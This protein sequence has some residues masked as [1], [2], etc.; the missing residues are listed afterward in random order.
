MAGCYEIS[1]QGRAL[2]EDIV[3]PEM[4][5]SGVS[6]RRSPQDVGEVLA[7]ECRFW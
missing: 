4:T 6:F 3:S 7:K 5:A 1:D 2:T